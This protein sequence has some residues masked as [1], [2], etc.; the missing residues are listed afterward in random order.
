M[1]VAPI[2][3]R[4]KGWSEVENTQGMAEKVGTL[5]ENLELLVLTMVD[6][7]TRKELKKEENTRFTIYRNLASPT[8][9]RMVREFNIEN[10]EEEEL[11]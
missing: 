1:M 9:L 10:L 7:C 6:T 11:G 8:A 5:C 4:K 3:E 2:E